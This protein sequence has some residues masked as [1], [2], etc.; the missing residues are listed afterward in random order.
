M[1]TSFLDRFDKKILQ[2][3]QIS[4]KVTS[5]QLSEQIGLS[6]ASI[7]RRINKLRKRKVI[8]SDVSV[9]DPYTVG[10]DMTFITLVTLER[11][12]TRIIQSYKQKWVNNKN[13]QQ[14]YYV[15][16]TSDF[17]IIITCKN[18]HEY[19][20]LT[21]SLFFDDDNVKNFH[22]SIVMESMKVSLQVPIEI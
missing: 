5:D 13:V 18:M 16:G 20:E 21:K 11:E 8:S 7:Q 15:T 12:N 14:C 9:I 1:D 2:Q 4:N 22:T 19:N 3:L 6:P 10:M 17:V